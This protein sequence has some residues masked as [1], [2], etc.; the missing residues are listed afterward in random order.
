MPLLVAECLLA[1][2]LSDFFVTLDKR[3][4][5]RP[6]AP[7]AD[8]LRNKTLTSAVMLRSLESHYS[9]IY[10]VPVPTTLLLSSQELT[11]TFPCLTKVRGP[12]AIHAL[13]IACSRQSLILGI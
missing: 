12:P 1:A 10:Q 11:T 5:A 7:W 13:P 4:P 6:A 2:I 8:R 9:S 3:F